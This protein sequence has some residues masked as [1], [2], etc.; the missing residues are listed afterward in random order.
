MNVNAV[1]RSRDAG[2]AVGQGVS[3]RVEDS[4]NL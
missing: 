4:G 2:A 3:K 1:R